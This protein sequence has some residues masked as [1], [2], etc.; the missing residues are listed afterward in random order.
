MINP[1]VIYTSLR[2]AILHWLIHFGVIWVLF[3]AFNTGAY[4]I[5]VRNGDYY[6]FYADGTHVPVWQYFLNDNIHERDM[7]LLFISLFFVEFN[8]QFVFRRVKLPVFIMSC[9]SLSVICYLILMTWIFRSSIV[10]WHNAR[11]DRQVQDRIRAA[12]VNSAL[13][14]IET[15]GSN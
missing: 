7:L 3:N 2:K 4:A 11:V 10:D 14:D 6:L 12:C 5:H 8:Y 9:L 1:G 13:W 15:E